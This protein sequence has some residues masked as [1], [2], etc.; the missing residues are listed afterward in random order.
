[1]WPRADNQAKE[2]SGYYVKLA[3]EVSVAGNG[4]AT[5]PLPQVINL[6]SHDD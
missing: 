6:L 4:P 1:M 2:R 5:G 3:A